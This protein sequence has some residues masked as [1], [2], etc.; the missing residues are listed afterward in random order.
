MASPV[1]PMTKIDMTEQDTSLYIDKMPMTVFSFKQK[2]EKDKETEAKLKKILGALVDRCRKNCTPFED[3]DFGPTEEDEYGSCAL[4]GTPPV[5]PPPSGGKRYPDPDRLRWERPKYKFNKI[6]SSNNQDDKD[7]STIATEETKGS[8][9]LEDNDDEENYNEEDNDNNNNDDDDDDDEFGDDEWGNEDLNEGWCDAAELF[10]DGASSGDVIQGAL[11]DCWFLGAL[12]VVGTREKETQELFWGLDEFKEYGIYVCRFYKDHQWRYV[13][14][15]DR[16]P[17]WDNE[18]PSPVFASCK[19]VNEIWVPLIE[20]AYAKLHGGYKNLIRG[21]LHLALADLTGFTPMLK[22][23]KPG[24]Q[25]YT[26]NSYHCQ[27]LSSQTDHKVKKEDEVNELWKTIV[28]YIEWGALLGCSIQQLP[29]VERKAV[30]SEMG[31]GLILGH[32]YGLINAASISTQPRETGSITIEGQT[33]LIEIR[34]PWGHKEW[35]GNWSDERK[36]REEYKKE[37][38]TKFAQGNETVTVNRGDGTFFMSKEDFFFQFTHLFIAFPPREDWKN[39]IYHSRF[40]SDRSGPRKSKTW[41]L[42]PR[43]SFDLEKETR[44]LISLQLP[45]LRLSYGYN[46]I[47]RKT[48]CQLIAF[49]IVK[50]KALEE[51]DKQAHVDPDKEIF[52]TIQGSTNKGVTQV[53]YN[54]GV[55]GCQLDVRLEEGQYYFVPSIYQ[56]GLRSRFFVVM[57]AVPDSNVFEPNDNSNRKKIIF[58]HERFLTPYKG[59]NGGIVVFQNSGKENSYKVNFDE[60]NFDKVEETKVIFDPS[61]VGDEVSVS[62]QNLEMVLQKKHEQQE[63][64][65][66]KLS[67]DDRKIEEQ[68]K[69]RANMEK[70]REKFM[71]QIE[72][73]G[74]QVLDVVKELTRKGA[75]GLTSKE[76]RLILMKVGVSLKEFEDEDLH[77]IDLDHNGKIDPDEIQK[78]F[79]VGDEI[80]NDNMPPLQP[81][82]DDLIFKSTAVSGTL[83]VKVLEGKGLVHPTT[84][85]HIQSKLLGGSGNENNSNSYNNNSNN[86]NSKNNDNNMEEE[87]NRESNGIHGK[88]RS[89]LPI[90]PV[91]HSIAFTDNSSWSYNGKRNTEEKEVDKKNELL[92][93]N[94]HLDDTNEIDNTAGPETEKQIE[95][96]V[97]LDTEND[98]NNSKN[99]NLE[100]GQS[101]RERL[102]IIYFIDILRQRQRSIST[103]NN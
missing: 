58:D 11:G 99:E 15:D 52:E 37:I 80:K 25:G 24:F 48:P 81:P 18:K 4:Y 97:E 84:W 50:R 54:Y 20:K 17:V 60:V 63:Q 56:R 82:P 14:I 65:H 39:V 70:T 67:I 43:L 51:A 101:R 85:F 61:E 47:S 42:N 33:D 66:A 45:D 86:N 32:A 7:S 53:T 21:H 3:P 29:G 91:K 77:C 64:K 22:I 38:K 57:H 75:N 88:S 27:S 89:I 36:E 79:L 13:I 23:F 12:S 44:L 83:A 5:L 103:T 94:N 78:F 41:T 9:F 2:S 73:S 26:G 34:N 74:F 100:K 68:N 59:K 95:T 6:K 76:F 10:I 72:E 40:D 55:Y 98:E 92:E 1:D 46:Y 30:E 71:I 93:K 19:D 31:K 90:R 102:R 87:N 96:K 28:Q 35:T 69:K 62:H 8:R 16:I 49:D